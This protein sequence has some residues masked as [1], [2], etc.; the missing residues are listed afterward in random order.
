MEPR[1][2]VLGMSTLLLFAVT[3]L[4]Y[5]Y[6]LCRYSR[7]KNQSQRYVTCSSELLTMVELH[8]IEY[9]TQ[10]GTLWMVIL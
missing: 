8:V 6:I 1:L 9:S 5:Y 3:L 7:M 4:C 2:E 10:T